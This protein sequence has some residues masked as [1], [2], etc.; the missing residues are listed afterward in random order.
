M[1]PGLETLVR[2]DKPINAYLLVNI[3]CASDSA[4]FPVDIVRN[5]HLLTYL[6]IKIEIVILTH[7]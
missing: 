5:T 4:G 3:V 7:P 6:F 1:V 2:S